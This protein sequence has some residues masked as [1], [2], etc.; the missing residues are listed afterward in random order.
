MAKGK[1]ATICARELFSLGLFTSQMLNQHLG[2][3]A[4]LRN[5]RDAPPLAGTKRKAGAVR[6]ELQELDDELRK[7]NKNKIDQNGGAAEAGP[8]KKK[9]KKAEAENNASSSSSASSD[10]SKDKARNKTGTKSEL[11]PATLLELRPKIPNALSKMLQCDYECTDME[12][13]RFHRD[14]PGGVTMAAAPNLKKKRAKGIDLSKESR[15]V[16]EHPCIHMH[17]QTYKTYKKYITYIT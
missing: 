15:K 10:K 9:K 7:V 1:A 11:K 13:R 6:S 14:F 2:E 16:R 12:L 5:S 8:A 17:A 3:R 4:A